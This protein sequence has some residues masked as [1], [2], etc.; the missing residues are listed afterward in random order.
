MI[1][2]TFLLSSVDHMCFLKTQ[3]LSLWPLI[4]SYTDMSDYYIAGLLM[5]SDFMIY[6]F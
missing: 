1:N 2:I 5:L 3:I 6:I 4:F